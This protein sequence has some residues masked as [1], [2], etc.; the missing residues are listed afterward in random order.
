MDGGKKMN[1]EAFSR[2]GSG[3]WAGATEDA[4]A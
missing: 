1:P 4:A 3:L 2:E